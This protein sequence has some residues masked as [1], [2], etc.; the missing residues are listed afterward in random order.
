[1]LTRSINTENSI[2]RRSNFKR[3]ALLFLISA[4][5]SG[6][7]KTRM[8]QDRQFFCATLQKKK[9]GTRPIISYMVYLIMIDDIQLKNDVLILVSAKCKCQILL[10][11]I[12]D[13]TN[14]G[15]YHAVTVETSEKKVY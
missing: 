11:G 12:F 4:N 9:D 10:Q 1:M 8:K 7:F 3:Q 5:L 14:I 15:S 6:T 13:L 2:I